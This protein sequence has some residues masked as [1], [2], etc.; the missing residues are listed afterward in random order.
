MRVHAE[1]SDGSSGAGGDALGLGYASDGDDAS[2]G[3]QEAAAAAV[4]VEAEPEQPSQITSAITEA[5]SADT[6]VAAAQPDTEP[7]QANG[8]EHAA[9]ST[10]DRSSK[11]VVTDIGPL[12]QG[13]E[14]TAVT[15]AAPA[16]PHA[17]PAPQAAE[18]LQLA[19]SS[20]DGVD[21]PPFSKGDR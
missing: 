7:A 14:G 18:G 10:D 16:G 4:E 15:V 19:A 20:A 5:A 1:D 3:S 12:E 2:A 13:I 21:A 9:A 11:A 8:V 17:E 6:S